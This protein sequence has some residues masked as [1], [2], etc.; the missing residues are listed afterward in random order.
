MRA[1]RALRVVIS[2]CMNSELR[3]AV[4]PPGNTFWLMWL[5]SS[6][7]PLYICARM[8]P[9]AVL[10]PPASQWEGRYICNFRSNR[11]LKRVKRVKRV[12]LPT[13]CLFITEWKH[14][15]A[16]KRCQVVSRIIFHLFYLV[17][18]RKRIRAK[19]KNHCAIL[20]GF[21]REDKS[22]DWNELLLKSTLDWWI[23]NKAFILRWL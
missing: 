22:K 9:F 18:N 1:L 13:T 14:G 11:T 6:C 12:L 17:K 16:V 19:I 10:N 20:K 5:P 21:L 4:C 7:E 2:G 15:A 23:W 8:Y 3:S